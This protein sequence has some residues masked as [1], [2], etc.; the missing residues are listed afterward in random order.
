MPAAPPP[1]FNA[2]KQ[3]VKRAYRNLAVHLARSGN[4]INALRSA[5]NGFFFQPAFSDL[6]FFLSLLRK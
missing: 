3:L 2:W 6:R 4:Q 1:V 5:I